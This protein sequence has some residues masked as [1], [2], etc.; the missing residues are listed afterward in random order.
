[1]ENILILIV[2]ASIGFPINGLFIMFLWALTMIILLKGY[3]VEKKIWTLTCLA[4]LSCIN[5]FYIPT[6]L[7][8]KLLENIWENIPFWVFNL[9][10]AIIFFFVSIIRKWRIEGGKI[11]ILY[12]TC[13][14]LTTVILFSDGRMPILGILYLCISV[15][16]LPVY[17]F[18]SWR[19]IVNKS[20]KI[21]R[22]ENVK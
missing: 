22:G 7:E 10:I 18:L 19:K 9:I 1:M 13:M 14:L 4:F 6:L 12:I 3:I 20:P 21:L 11:G 15:I 2:F 5:I 17:Y 16:F 8:Y